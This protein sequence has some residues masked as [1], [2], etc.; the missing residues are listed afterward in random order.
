MSSR[1]PR[2]VGPG[3][4][5]RLVLFPT[6]NKLAVVAATGTEGV[7]NRVDP[8]DVIAWLQSL[9]AESPVHLVFCNHELV[10]GAFVGRSNRPKSWR[11]AWLSSAPVVWTKVMA[12]RKS[13]RRS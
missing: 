6:E 4:D 8:A 5:A 3:E 1:R 9:D 11:S 13:S 12:M 2:G 10:G 7:N